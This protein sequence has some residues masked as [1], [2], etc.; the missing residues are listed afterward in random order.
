[1]TARERLMLM[2]RMADVLREGVDG[3][4]PLSGC[5]MLALR[6]GT[7][8]SDVVV[9]G[10]GV[11]KAIVDAE[12][13]ATG[14]GRQSFIINISQL[15]HCIELRLTS[16]AT[17]VARASSAIPYTAQTLI[18]NAIAKAS[19]KTIVSISPKSKERVCMGHRSESAKQKKEENRR[20]QDEGNKYQPRSLCTHKQSHLTCF[21]CGSARMQ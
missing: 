6:L 7:N 9:A 8:D 13:D 17:R 16:H 1:M 14:S 12:I 19:F 10:F 4:S 5:V 15:S 18:D 11:S 2:P 20:A 21:A 3:V